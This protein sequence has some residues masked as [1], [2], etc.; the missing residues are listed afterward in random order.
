MFSTLDPATALV[1][2]DLQRGI[3]GMALTHP[4]ED[5]VTRSAA[6]AAAFREHSLPVVLVNVAGSPP[7]RTDAESGAPRTFP[8]GWTEL[9]PELDRQP[10]DLVVTKYA[11]SAF[12]G[13]GLAERL[14]ALGVTQV[15]VT[16]ISTSGGVES[17]ARSA[18]EDGFNVSLP[19]DAMTDRTPEA[20]AYSVQNIFPRIAETGTTEELLALLASTRG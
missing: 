9:A 12:A 18:H 13:T 5:V 8:E 6:L 15:V 7:G 3:T 2:I 14:R 1:V 16:G 11:R 10:E 17:T 20:H 19:V 4:T